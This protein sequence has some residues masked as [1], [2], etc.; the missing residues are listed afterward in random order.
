MDIAG[1]QVVNK[2]GKNIVQVPLM[3]HQAVSHFMDIVSPPL[4][5]DKSGNSTCASRSL[6]CGAIDCASQ[7]ENSE[8]DLS[9]LL[10][11]S[12]PRWSLC[13]FLLF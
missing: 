1:H 5:I 3:V 13:S 9:G 8:S 12:L 7:D 2:R 6:V 4:W 11:R 10:R